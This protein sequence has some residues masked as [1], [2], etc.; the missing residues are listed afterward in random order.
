LSA[1]L[2][3]MAREFSLPLRTRTVPWPMISL[4]A[5]GMEAI[6]RLGDGKEP[7]LTRYSAGVLAFSQTL[8]I[9]ALR[10]DLGYQPKVS[11]SEGIR[12]HAVWWRDHQRESAL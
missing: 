10:N 9:S 8:D 5:R 3:L 1:L 11:I 12:R 7:L 2:E 6:A 4:L